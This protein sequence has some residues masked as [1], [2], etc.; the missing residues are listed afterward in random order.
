MVKTHWS[1]VSRGICAQP[2]A[3]FT[4]SWWDLVD[5]H[6][7]DAQWGEWHQAPDF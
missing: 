6:Y 4:S 1:R 7:M 3:A 5:E 2:R